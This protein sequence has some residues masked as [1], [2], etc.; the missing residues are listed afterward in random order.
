MPVVIDGVNLRNVEIGRPKIIQKL[1]GLCKIIKFDCV[2]RLRQGS[3]NDKIVRSRHCIHFYR[4]QKP[5]GASDTVTDTKLFWRFFFFSCVKLSEEKT[6][7]ENL[8]CVNWV[9]NTFMERKKL[10]RINK[11]KKKLN[12]QDNFVFMRETKWKCAFGR[13]IIFDVVVL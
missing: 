7:Q 6:F 10:T 4:L 12:S 1:L 9:K 5:W 8:L 13:R 2:L 11:W 3:H